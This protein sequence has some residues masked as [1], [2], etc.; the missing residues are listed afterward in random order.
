MRPRFCPD[1]GGRLELRDVE[2]KERSFCTRCARVHYAQLKVGAG[3]LIVQEGRL[4]PI[5]R[6]RD[7]FSGCWNLPAGYAEADEAPVETVVRE[8]WEETGL[9]VEPAGLVDLYYF[10]DDWRGNGILIV[11]ACRVAVG[12]PQATSEGAMPTFFAPGDVPRELAGAGHDQAVRA[13]MRAQRP[14][15]R[16]QE[17]I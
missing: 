3:G 6:T 12:L 1:C 7:P 15:S 14:R 5:K 8:V 11:Y 13:W 9:R 16:S 4:L 17:G 10:D 2:G